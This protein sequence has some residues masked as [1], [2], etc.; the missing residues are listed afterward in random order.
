[1]KGRERELASLLIVLRLWRLVKL[2]GGKSRIGELSSWQLF[3]CMMQVSPSEQESSKKT[4]QRTL[5]S[6][7]GNM[8]GLSENYLQLRKRTSNSD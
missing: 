2:V 7:A 1:M 3:T 5:L 4:L 6:S 8:V